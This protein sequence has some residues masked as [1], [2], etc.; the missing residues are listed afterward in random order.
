[1]GY[2]VAMFSGTIRALEQKDISAIEDIFDLYWSDD[3]RS[4]LSD[5]LK[6]SNLDWIVAEEN[7]EIVGV[8]ASRKAPVRMREYAQTSNVVEFYVS[9]AKYKNRGIG[10]ALREERIK[11]ARNDGYKEAVFFSGET[12]QDSW[13]FHDRSDFS[14]AGEFM[15]PDGENGFIWL[16]NL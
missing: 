16:M 5:R 13:G 2:Y 3:F 7:G 10:T 8:A 9:A 4:H 6:S 14:R 11:Q 1:M 12:H 15:A